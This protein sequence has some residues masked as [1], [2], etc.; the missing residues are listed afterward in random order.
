MSHSAVAVAAP[1]LIH[2]HFRSDPGAPVSV[3]DCQQDDGQPRQDRPAHERDHGVPCSWRRETVQQD[4][5]HR[6]KS[7]SSDTEQHE[8]GAE[9]QGFK[10]EPNEAAAFPPR[11]SRC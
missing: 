11:R 6:D 8:A 9:R 2:S 3:D 1:Q 5:H 4:G 7:E 10:V